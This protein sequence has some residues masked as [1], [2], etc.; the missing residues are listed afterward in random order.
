MGFFLILT[1][2]KLFLKK[3]LDATILLKRVYML[4]LIPISWIVFSIH[5][6]GELAVYLRKLFDFTSLY[7]TAKLWDLVYYAKDYAWMAVLGI[8]LCTPLPSRIYEAKKKNIVTLLI[9]LAIFWL[10]VH[11]IISADSNPFLYANF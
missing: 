6:P 3:A 10:S 8:L 5:D 2:E 11:Q 7:D 4:I 9:L 1:I